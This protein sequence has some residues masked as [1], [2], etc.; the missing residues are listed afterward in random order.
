MGSL[1]TVN[2]FRLL[3]IIIARFS[4]AA[5]ILTTQPSVEFNPVTGS[6]KLTI[7]YFIAG[8][9]NQLSANLVNVVT[10]YL[11]LALG[12]KVSLV[13]IRVQN[14][15]ADANVLARYLSSL[16]GGPA[17]SSHAFKAVML[18]LAKFLAFPS[19][20]VKGVWGINAPY[21]LRGVRVRVSGRLT[22]E[23]T[24]PRQTTHEFTL[25]TFKTNRLQAGSFTVINSKG[26]M[27][28]K[29]W[30]GL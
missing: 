11:S 16:M 23:P 19:V 1:P 20:A 26:A 10:D 28:V 7:G 4:Q 9:R 24:R 5:G 22:V 14:P 18:Q 15:Y 2:Q 3:R 8:E 21:A 30:L 25:G 27:T 13:L 6:L 12:L 17:R 29:V